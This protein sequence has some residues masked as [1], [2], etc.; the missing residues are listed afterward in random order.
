MFVDNAVYNEEGI[1]VN[2]DNHSEVCQYYAFFFGL[3]KDI[4]DPKFAYLKDLFLVF[5]AL[6]VR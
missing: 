2:T 6:T 1:A 4:D 5:S 3:V